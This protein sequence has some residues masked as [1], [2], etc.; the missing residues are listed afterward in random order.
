MIVVACTNC[1]IGLRVIGDDREIDTLVGKSSDFFP[2]N[3]VC[4]R[5][6]SRAVCVAEDI[7]PP[8]ELVDL[9]AE[10]LFAALNGLGLP[11]EQVCVRS[12]VEALLKEK[13]IRRV[14]G[15]D[16]AG[17]QRF[18]LEHLELWDGTR[19]YFGAAPE[20]AIIYRVVRPP[21]ATERALRG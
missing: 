10:E 15:T 19:L 8:V 17:S 9:S 11:E 5:C 21:N 16:I 14:V 3:Y 13:P 12:V 4:P 20:G 6:A 2:D 18:C 1:G 7:C